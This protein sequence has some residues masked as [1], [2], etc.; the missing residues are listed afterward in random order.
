ML[1]SPQILKTPS[2]LIE[3]TSILRLCM[4]LSRCH[5]L[6]MLGLRRFCYS[7]SML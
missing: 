1:D 3:C 2:I 6:G 7:M 5:R 4:G